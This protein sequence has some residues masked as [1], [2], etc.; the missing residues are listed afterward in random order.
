[1]NS[2]GASTSG[3]RDRR[4]RTGLAT[5]ANYISVV[6]SLIKHFFIW[7][8]IPVKITVKILPINI[9]KEIEIKSGS[10]ISDIIKRIDMKPDSVI[11]LK[12]NTPIPIDDVLNTDQELKIVQVA[13]GG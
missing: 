8:S 7:V 13:S 4:R 2:C 5:P 1:M 9:K 11:I 10:K 6:K 3:F 12:E